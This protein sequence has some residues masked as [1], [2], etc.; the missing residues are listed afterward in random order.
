MRY[1][2]ILLFAANFVSYFALVSLALV[3]PSLILSLLF[4]HHV[5]A[6]NVR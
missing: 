3:S 6:F 4:T 1:K 2:Q 5:L